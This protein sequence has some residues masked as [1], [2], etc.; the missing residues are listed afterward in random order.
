MLPRRS[1]WPRRPPLSWLPSL[2]S[3]PFDRAMLDVMANARHIERVR[4][5]TASSPAA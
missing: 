5:S 4:W 2:A 3:L 1:C